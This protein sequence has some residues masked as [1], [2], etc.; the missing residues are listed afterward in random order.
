MKRYKRLFKEISSQEEMNNK[1]KDTMAKYATIFNKL[2][3]E[4]LI[5]KEEYRKIFSLISFYLNKKYKGNVTILDYWDTLLK[6]E[7]KDYCYPDLWRKR[8]GIF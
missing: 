8:R 2:S 3:Y 6:G 5:K 4:D 7:N 1:V